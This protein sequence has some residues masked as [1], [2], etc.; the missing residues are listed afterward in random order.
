LLV[1]AVVGGSTYLLT[2][3]AGLLVNLADAAVERALFDPRVR[4]KN[5]VAP[6]A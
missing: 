2:A 1:R 4:V 3:V 5:G 6:T